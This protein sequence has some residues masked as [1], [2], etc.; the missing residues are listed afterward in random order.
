MINID[1]QILKQT[2]EMFEQLKDEVELHVFLTGEQC[3]YCNETR[4][5]VELIEQQSPLIKVKYCD[6]EP[7]STE[8]DKFKIDKHPAIVIRS[9]HVKGLVRFFGI[10]AGYEFG[11]LIETIIEASTGNIDLSEHTRKTLL[12]LTENN[13]VHLQVFITPTCPWCPGMVRLAHQFAMISPHVTGDMVEA[14]EFRELS[15]K[16][17]VMGVPRTIINETGSLEG[18]VPEPALLKKI[19]EVLK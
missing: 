4:S 2:K 17:K 3:L 19:E 5:L 1:P 18:A 12:Q 16:Y 8:G 10:P 14:I 6:C 11:S 7:G 9:K 15:M 13:P